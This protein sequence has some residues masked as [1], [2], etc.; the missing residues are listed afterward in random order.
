MNWIYEK[1]A[2]IRRVLKQL[3]S[4]SKTV[5][6][7]ELFKF[8]FHCNKIVRNYMNQKLS[9]IDYAAGSLHTELIES[10]FK[11]KRFTLQ[12]FRFCIF[13]FLNF[14]LKLLQHSRWVL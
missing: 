1:D 8:K 13:I 5:F 2:L 7:F 9:V 11:F 10:I 6:K 12:L 4:D 14:D 3:M